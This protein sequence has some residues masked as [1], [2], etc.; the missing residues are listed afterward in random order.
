MHTAEPA[1]WMGKA[2]DSTDWGIKHTGL[3]NC[4]V[5]GNHCCCFPAFT[6]PPQCALALING[7]QFGSSS[8][9]CWNKICTAVEIRKMKTH[10]EWQGGGGRTFTNF[11]WVLKIKVLL[12][13]SNG[14]AVSQ[15]TVFSAPRSVHDGCMYKCFFPP[16]CWGYN[17]EV[18][19]W[20]VF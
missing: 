3:C 17:T 11:H 16:F 18:G 15:G 20:L 1:A 6:L 13:L 9:I 10:Y 19:L 12:F 5:L 2:Q 4:W 14:I 7:D 8:C